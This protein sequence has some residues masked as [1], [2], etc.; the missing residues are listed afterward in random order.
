MINEQDEGRKTDCLF[1]SVTRKMVRDYCQL[2]KDNNPIFYHLETAKKAGYNDLLIPS[3]YPSLFW[4]QIHIPWLTEEM[5]F[6]QQEQTITFKK[7]LIANK[8]YGCYIKLSKISNIKD[9]QLLKHRLYIWDEE[10]LTATS[11]TTII[12]QKECLYGRDI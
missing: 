1:I 12:L 4:Q 8:Q 10:D 2:T 7:P 5:E 3:T 6:I 9:H 11:D